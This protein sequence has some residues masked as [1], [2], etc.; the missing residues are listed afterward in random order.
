M[1]AFQ[2]TK[3][4]SDILT[5]SKT[6]GNGIPLASVITSSEI[7]EATKKKGF[8]FY[9]THTNEPLPCAVGSKVL[10]VFIRDNLPERWYRLGIK[11]R[12]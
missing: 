2:D 4:V 12:D 11:F 7:A 9:T 6:L 8:L 1:F 3:I 10:E 5:F